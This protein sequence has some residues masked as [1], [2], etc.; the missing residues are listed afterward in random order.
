M[1]AGTFVLLALEPHLQWAVTKIIMFT[2]YI[3]GALIFS[4]VAIDYGASMGMAG[5]FVA[6][7]A[8]LV[9]VAIIYLIASL[10]VGSRGQHV[11]NAE[12][13]TRE[14]GSQV[15]A[16]NFVPSDAPKYRSVTRRTLNAIKVY[17]PKPHWRV[18]NDTRTTRP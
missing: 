14:H 17:K 1:G 12:T 5:W 9:G 8:L 15:A 7:C 2:G 10:A 4:L 11:P 3:V 6:A 13:D 18:N 16:P